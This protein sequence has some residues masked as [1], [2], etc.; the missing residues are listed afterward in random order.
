ME[1]FNLSP[2]ECSILE[3]PPNSPRPTMAHI[4]V[5]WDKVECILRPNISST[6]FTNKT[7]SKEQIF[8]IDFENCSQAT[9]LVITVLDG[10]KTF[11]LHTDR[12]PYKNICLKAVQ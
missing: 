8:I 4:V 10:K 2:E 12:G 11:E 5:N 3:I 7:K 6:S 9:K 1:S